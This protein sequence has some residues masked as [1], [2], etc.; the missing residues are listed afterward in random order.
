MRSTEKILIQV[1]VIVL[2]I[3]FL[4]KL[5]FIQVV[6]STY[7][8]AADDNII[9][10]II[11]YPYRGTIEDRNGKLLVYNQPIYDL[12][13]VPKEVRVKD[14]AR[15]CQIFGITLEEFKEKYQEAQKYSYVKSSI[16]IKQISH[17]DFARIQDHLVDYRVCHKSVD[18]RIL[19]HVTKLIIRSYSPII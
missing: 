15:F 8:K 19:T 6:D 14:T 17:Q 12:Q 18:V 16:F 10:K 5:F 4:A 7:K 3:V 2:G 11:E 1:F 9:Q 13:I